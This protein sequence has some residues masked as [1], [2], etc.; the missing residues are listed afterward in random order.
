VESYVL[1]FVQSLKSTNQF[2]LLSITVTFT[3]LCYTRL[4]FR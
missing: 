2:F 4:L 1:V 3:V